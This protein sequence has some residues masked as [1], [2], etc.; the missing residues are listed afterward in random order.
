[1][2]QR[3]PSVKFVGVAKLP[4][5][6]LVFTRKSVNRGCGVADVVRDER[7]DVWG[8]IF[9][10]SGLD[11]AALDKSEGYRSSRQENSYWRR[12]CTV[13]LEGDKSR[14]VAAFTYFAEPQQ[15]PPLPNEAYKNLIISGARHWHLPDGYIEELNR[16]E[17][18][19]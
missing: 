16:I 3:C 11:V 9:K 19:G 10:I 13:F 7:R 4:R 18:S 2:K 5:H 15:N 6:R 17:V 12:K 1:M 14:P 8:A